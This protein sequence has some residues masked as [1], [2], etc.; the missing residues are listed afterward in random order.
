MKLP[1][2]QYLCVD[3]Q[4]VPY[5]GSLALK[6]YMKGK[7]TP[8]G[9]KIFL[10]CGQPGMMYNLFLYQGWTPDLDQKDLKTFGLGGAVVLKLVQNIKKKCT[11]LIF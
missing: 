7:P 4:I 2:K 9:V 5:K 3:E 6:Q 1:V 11:L 8:W 10:L